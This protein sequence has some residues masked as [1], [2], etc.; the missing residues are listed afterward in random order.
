MPKLFGMNV[1][2]HVYQLNKGRIQSPRRRNSAA[3]PAQRSEHDEQAKLFEWAERNMQRYPDLW[4]LHAIPNGGHRHPAV[5]AK[6]KAEGV[7]S[8]VPD[9]CL[10][11]PRGSYCGLY[12]EMKVG[13]NKPTDSQA[14][15]L[16]RLADQGYMTAVCYGWV[17][18]SEVIERYLL[19]RKQ[20]GKRVS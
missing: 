17:E 19:C 15:W 14:E 20:T 12:I 16:K 3:T 1:S 6:L 2:D 13:R 5:A 9:V 11:V 4:L 10:P 18:A 8:G 7:K